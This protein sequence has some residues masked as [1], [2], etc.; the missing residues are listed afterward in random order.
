MPLRPGLAKGSGRTDLE[1]VQIHVSR[2]VVISQFEILI[3][4]EDIAGKEVRDNELVFVKGK[5]R[6]PGYPAGSESD[7]RQVALQAGGRVLAAGVPCLIQTG[8]VVMNSSAMSPDPA[9]LRPEGAPGVLSRMRGRFAN[10][11]S[12]FG[13][14]APGAEW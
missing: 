3:Q 5:D 4:R 12:P 2:Q 9:S 6:K 7:L 14:S 10:Q 8:E 11:A 13:D 1:D